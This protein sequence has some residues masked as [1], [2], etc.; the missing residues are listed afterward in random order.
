MTKSTHNYPPLQM[1]IDVDVKAYNGG[2]KI[3]VYDD[4]KVIYDEQLSKP[5]LQQIVINTHVLFPNKLTIEHYD[6]QPNDTKV[7]DNGMILADKGV[8]INRIILNDSALENELYLFPTI[9]EDGE[10]LTKNNYLGH[11]SKFVIDVDHANIGFW[12]RSIQKYVA[13]TLEQFD[14]DTFKIE[15]FGTAD[16]SN[17][18]QY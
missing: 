17:L 3:K 12:Q 9:L 16:I 14:Y 13:S 15:L 8:A 18:V 7:A 2:P 5:G 11:N 4:E 6:K 1:V 10:I